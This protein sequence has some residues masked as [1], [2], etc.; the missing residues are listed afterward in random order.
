MRYRPCY[1]TIVLMLSLFL[2][3]GMSADSTAWAEGTTLY[4]DDDAVNDP[5]PDDPTVSDP[6]ED[7]SAEHP[8]DA[9]QEAIDAASDGDT[10]I[11]R[12]GVYN[13]QGNYNIVLAG[14]A[15]HL[16]GSTDPQNTLIVPAENSRALYFHSNEG[17][18]TVVE[19]FLLGMDERLYDVDSVIYCKNA[20]P[21][22]RNCIIR[23]GRTT[24]GGGLYC[25]DSSPQIIDCQFSDNTVTGCGG[26]IY[27][28]GDSAPLLS[29]CAIMGNS[30]YT[31]GGIYI[32]YSSPVITD[33]FFIGNIGEYGGAINVTGGH[34]LIKGN[35]FDRNYSH[36]TGAGIA[37]NGQCN[38]II[39]DNQVIDNIA[40][41]GTG[42]SILGGGAPTISNNVIT[43]NF[44]YDRD[45]GGVFNRDGCDTIIVDNVISNNRA[46]HHGGGIFTY[47]SAPTIAGNIISD[48]WTEFD[49]G[50]INCYKNVFATVVDNVITGNESGRRAGGIASYYGGASVIHNNV[51][52][53]NFSNSNAGGIATWRE[54]SPT[55][56]GN[57]IADNTA[58]PGNC[59]GGLYAEPG[60]VL[61]NN[62][63]VGNWAS[64]GGGVFCRYGEIAMDATTIAD[65]EAEDF[66]GG[67][68]CMFDTNMTLT[69]SILWNN[70]A[71]KGSEAYL[72]VNSH[73]TYEYCD[74]ADLATSTFVYGGSSVTVGDGVF[75]AD[76]LFA[77][78]DNGDYH[79]KSAYGRWMV[80]PDG[81]GGEWVTDN[82][83]SPCIDAGSPAAECVNEPMP[84]G[85]IV[86]LGAYGNT[87]YAS[88]SGPA[89][90]GDVTADCVV[91]VLDLI[92]VRNLLGKD[93]Y[94]DGNGCADLNH[95]G[96]INVLDL[97]V[98][99]NNLGAACD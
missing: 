81:E 31:G 50:G 69:N 36:H 78:A 99:R 89:V 23:G 44:S 65:N 47:C 51:I 18:D 90:R 61:A 86:N 70:H 75:Q 12:P 88:R 11:A 66:G 39:T 4:V 63:I 64:L 83:M 72:N 74:V 73:M 79:L 68:G 94:S 77:D 93:P 20:S 48:N 28:T 3:A 59:G 92:T 43:G 80:G 21:T 1:T 49:G 33:S 9:I 54:S 76:P 6:L 97:L 30:G 56:T 35:T 82:V 5:G 32:Y 17:P 13:G 7:G 16:L 40:Y 2:T 96:V 55:I 24:N 58:A 22:I 34:A 19:G 71:P 26:A 84:N 27:I 37:C 46:G 14:K 91:N 52:Q 98:V 60:A 29:G 95:D 45:G 62:L 8:F 10:V 25:E 38:A 57:I 87:V 42:I 85:S 15:V 53:G 41:D 67:I